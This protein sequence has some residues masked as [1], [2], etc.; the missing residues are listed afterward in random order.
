LLISHRLNTVRDADLLIILRDGV[1]IEQ[2]THD[3]LMRSGGAYARLFRMQAAGYRD[4]TPQDA[5]P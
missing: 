1:V 5:Q 3:T 2:G 4:R